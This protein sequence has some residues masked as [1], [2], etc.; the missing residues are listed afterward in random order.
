MCQFCVPMRYTVKQLT[1]N[2][3]S[4]KSLSFVIGKSIGDR[5]KSLQAALI[6]IRYFCPTDIGILWKLYIHARARACL[7]AC[8]C[9]CICEGVWIV[10]D[11]HYY[12]IVLQVYV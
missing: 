1:T 10:Y 11:Y 3:L 4:E 2:N 5:R 12:N 8:A 7:C 6:A 9:V